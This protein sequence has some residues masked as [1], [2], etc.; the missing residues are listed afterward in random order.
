VSSLRASMCCR[1]SSERQRRDWLLRI[2][3]FLI[4]LAR[5]G[6]FE[7]S[8]SEAILSELHRVLHDKFKWPES[9]I[10]IVERQIRGFARV[11]E[12]KQKFDVMRDDPAD[13]RIL[14]CT[15]AGGSDYIVTGDNHLLKLGQF[16]GTSIVP[17][18]AFLE[19][20]LQQRGR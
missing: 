7:V 18:A 4:R 15:V 8:V 20:Q 13:N 12:P 10:A 14:E 11:V 6:Q 5:A 3:H 9:D 16:A 17:P 19:I 2:H 1:S